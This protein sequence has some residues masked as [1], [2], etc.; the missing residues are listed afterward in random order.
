MSFV[1]S[2]ATYLSVIKLLL[3]LNI[4]S[5]ISS[6]VGRIYQS[7]NDCSKSDLSNNTVKEFR[8]KGEGGREGGGRE[9]RMERGKGRGVKKERIKRGK[10]RKREREGRRE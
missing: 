1:S 4:F 5:P 10:K 6:I 8:R 7:Q 9:G 2:Q 3:P